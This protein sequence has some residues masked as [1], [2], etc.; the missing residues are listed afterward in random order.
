[1]GILGNEDEPY[2]NT[3]LELISGSGR[4]ILQD[5]QSFGAEFRSSKSLQRFGNDMYI[6]INNE[7]MVP[8]FQ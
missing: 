2:L 5:A 8:L 7:I 6:N 3:A 4:S 1:M